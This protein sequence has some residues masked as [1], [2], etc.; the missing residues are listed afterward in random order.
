MKKL[1]DFRKTVETVL[2]RAYLINS[3]RNKLVATI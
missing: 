2:I 1:T 3:N